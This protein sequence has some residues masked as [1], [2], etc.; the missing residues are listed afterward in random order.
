MS[1]ATLVD[2][3]FYFFALL[4]LGSAFAFKSPLP[5]H[6]QNRCFSLM[7]WVI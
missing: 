1:K 6:F 2:V 7:F 3:G 4:L 5:V